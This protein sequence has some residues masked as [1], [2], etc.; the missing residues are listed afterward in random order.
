MQFVSVWIFTTLALMF[1]L[2][3]ASPMPSSVPN[4]PPFQCLREEG[5][6]CLP[7]IPVC[8]G[9]KGPCECC[10]ISRGFLEDAKQEYCLPKRMHCTSDGNFVAGYSGALRCHYPLLDRNLPGHQVMPRFPDPSGMEGRK[11]GDLKGF[12]SPSP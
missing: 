6:V 7:P 8:N 12:Q 3:A 4:L 1:P 9:P 2:I 11:I 5:F 10:I